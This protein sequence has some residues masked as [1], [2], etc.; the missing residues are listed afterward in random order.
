MF[1]NLILHRPKIVRIFGIHSCHSLEALY[2]CKIMYK[3]LKSF[4]LSRNYKPYNRIFHDDNKMLLSVSMT[5]LGYEKTEFGTW[6]WNLEKL[7]Y[8]LKAPNPHIVAWW[9]FKL[10]CHQ[11]LQEHDNFIHLYQTKILIEKISFDI[12]VLILLS[13]FIF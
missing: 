9:Y 10:N 5:T 8:G 11:N 4:Q 1:F 13:S 6:G 12:K 2:W 7:Q 3:Q